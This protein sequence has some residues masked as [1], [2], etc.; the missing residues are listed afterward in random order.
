MPRYHKGQ[1]RPDG[2]RLSVLSPLIDIIRITCGIKLLTI[3]QCLCFY[4]YYCILKA[5]LL[6]QLQA[7]LRLEGQLTGRWCI[8]SRHIHHGHE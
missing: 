3:G 5:H 4:I 1:P 2:D 8:Y 7:S 6:I